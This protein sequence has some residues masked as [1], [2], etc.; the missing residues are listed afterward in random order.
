MKKYRQYSQY[1]KTVAIFSLRH[2]YGLSIRDEKH[3]QKVP[4]SVPSKKRDIMKHKMVRLMAFLLINMD[5]I[6][7]VKK[8]IAFK[9]TQ[10]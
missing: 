1:V 6:L 8:G 10:I 5:W 7:I 4:Q 3:V 9:V 2:T